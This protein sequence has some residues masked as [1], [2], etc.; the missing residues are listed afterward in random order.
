MSTLFERLG[1]KPAVEAVVDK[2]Y[3]RVME[4]SRI[5][6]FFAGIDMKKQREHQTAFLIF[7][8]GGSAYHRGL[9]LRT[10]HQNLVEQF[11]GLRDEHFDAV[12]EHL[13]STLQELSVADNLIREAGENIELFRRYILNK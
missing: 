6:H 11:G 9:S 4:D 5:N 3:I 8:F 13:V 7:A 2:F 1:G 12:F 10:A